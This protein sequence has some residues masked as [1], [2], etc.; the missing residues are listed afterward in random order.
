MLRS[1]YPKPS[2]RIRIEG[3]AAPSSETSLEIKG[4]AGD[5]RPPDLW[6][7]RDRQSSS[8]QSS[9]SGD[10]TVVREYSAREIVEKLQTVDA[11]L[12]TGRSLTA[13]LR[14]IR[15]SRTSYNRWRAEYCGLRR[16]LDAPDSHPSARKAKPDPS[17]D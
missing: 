8:S 11:L 7:S 13:A 9:R 15:A 12:S 14:S 6:F 3:R 5:L 4:R 1:L 17:P 16:I 2:R 10:L